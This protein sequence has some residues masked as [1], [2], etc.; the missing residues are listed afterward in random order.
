M[1][2]VKLTANWNS[3]RGYHKAGETIDVNQ[4]QADK[5]VKIGKGYIKKESKPKKETK[6]DK[7]A[8]GK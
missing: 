1:A 4:N 8:T 5:I 3:G 6:E 2:K 7:V